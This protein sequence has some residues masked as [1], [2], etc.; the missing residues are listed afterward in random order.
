MSLT[1]EGAT[2]AAPETLKTIAATRA[3]SVTR[4]RCRDE[5]TSIAVLPFSGHPRALTIERSEKTG[6]G[7]Q[8]VERQAEGCL[9]HRPRARS[10]RDRR[11]PSRH[12]PQA[13]LRRFF[14]I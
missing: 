12:R 3:G 2:A 7:R 6:P 10:L 4:F 5:R 1:G 14:A 8:G 9:A 11:R 13:P